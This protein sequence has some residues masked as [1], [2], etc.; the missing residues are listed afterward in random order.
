MEIYVVSTL[1][2]EDEE[3]MVDALAT[4]LAELFDGLTIA[5]ALRIETSGTKVVQRTSL[6]AMD[7]PDPPSAS[8]HTVQ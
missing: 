3:R 2:L 5:Y 8:A 1:T 4:A 6:K 7:L